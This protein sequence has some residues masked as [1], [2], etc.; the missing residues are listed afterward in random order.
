MTKMAKLRI[1]LWRQGELASGGIDQWQEVDGFELDAEGNLRVPTSFISDHSQLQNLDADDHPQYLNKA[2]G[3][4]RY[5]LLNHNHDGVYEPAFSKGT[6][7]NRDFGTGPD[8]VARG[9]HSHNGVYANFVHNHDGVYAPVGHNH[10]AD[11]AA[12]THGH[13]VGDVT[14]LQAELDDKA[15]VAHTHTIAQVQGLQAELD[16]KEPAFVKNS[17]FNLPVGTVTGTVAAGDHNHDGRYSPANHTHPGLNDIFLWDTGSNLFPVFIDT[18]RGNKRLSVE[19][20]ITDYSRDGTTGATAMLNYVNHIDANNQ[21]RPHI[22]ACGVAVA[23]AHESA[24][25]TGQDIVLELYDA[26]NLYVLGTMVLPAQTAGASRVQT[27]VITANF[28]I[29]AGTTITWRVNTG[30]GNTVIDPRVTL[31][32]RWLF[33]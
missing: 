32:T 26:T 20:I 18:Y 10:D 6:A 23:Y 19:T 22:S 30:A 1:P 28:D 4:L 31:Y 25:T 14:G 5:A 13:T 17:G 15:P 33:V 7:F 2:R 29:A 8:N 27:E 21:W 12:L 3:D 16:G 9:D 11:Y 24:S